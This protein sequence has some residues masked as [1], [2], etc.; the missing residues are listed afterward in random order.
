[1]IKKL[2]ARSQ[3]N[4]ILK[5]SMQI[6]SP[7]FFWFLLLSSLFLFVSL[8][9]PFHSISQLLFDLLFLFGFRLQAPSVYNASTHSL[10]GSAHF[11]KIHQ[12]ALDKIASKAALSHQRATAF[13]TNAVLGIIHYI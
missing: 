2:N 12:F 7:F 9:P 5:K 6:C 10:S 3:G 1:M 8:L 4:S 11:L 13:D